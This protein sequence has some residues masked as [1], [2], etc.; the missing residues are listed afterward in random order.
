MDLYLKFIGGL[1]D[2]ELRSVIRQSS[3]AV[4]DKKSS[5]WRFVFDTSRSDTTLAL[6]NLSVG[7]PVIVITR[8]VFIPSY[9][10]GELLERVFEDATQFLSK[11]ILIFLS[12]S[13]RL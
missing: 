8:V 2:Y 12:L 11:T 5:K 13:S 3:R 10:L 7:F 4:C 9:S 1:C 6:L